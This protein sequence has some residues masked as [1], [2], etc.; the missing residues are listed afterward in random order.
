MK[1]Q[2]LI[3]VHSMNSPW[4]VYIKKQGY[5]VYQVLKN[6]TLPNRV[7]RKV[8]LCREKTCDTRWL[9]DWHRHIDKYSKVIIFANSLY[10]N[11]IKWIR[12]NAPAV[13]IIVWYM[14]PYISCQLKID[15]IPKIEEWSFDI[16]DCKSRGFFFKDSFYCFTEDDSVDRTDENEVDMFYIGSDKG[17]YKYIEKIRNKLT[18][19]GYKCDI[20]VTKDTSLLSLRKTIG[21]LHRK[22]DRPISYDEVIKCVKRSRAILDI[23]QE[24]QSGLSQRP[25]EALFYNKK[26][27][28]NNKHLLKA[29]FYNKN[30]IYLIQDFQLEGIE[31]FM[32]LPYIDIPEEVKKKYTFESW[33]SQF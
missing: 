14:D 25:F 11:V 13:R 21:R 12:D 20:R 3:L 24:F 9:E 30:N 27:I 23:Y 4:G 19:K 6:Q 5:E 33:I 16:E 26:L 22:Y 29:D 17:R 32:E 10:R 28:T 7:R 8:E 31:E 18:D 15:D 2:M 1:D